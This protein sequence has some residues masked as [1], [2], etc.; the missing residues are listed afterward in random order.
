MRALLLPFSLRVAPFGVLINTF[1]KTTAKDVEHLIP[2]LA[3][4]LI[5]PVEEN[6]NTIALYHIRF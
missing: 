5:N 4:A 2:A 3:E 6:P 1:T